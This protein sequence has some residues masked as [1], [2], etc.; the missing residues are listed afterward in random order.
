MPN[1]HESLLARLDERVKHIETMVHT[2]VTR[3]EFTPVKAI[4]FGLAGL[5]LCSVLAAVV[6][7]VLHK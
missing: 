5:I 4:A 7:T 1:D 2:L 6:A 3:V